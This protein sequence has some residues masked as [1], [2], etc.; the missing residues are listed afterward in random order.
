MKELINILLNVIIGCM[1]ITFI[2]FGC[3]VILIYAVKCF[4]LG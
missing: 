4:L 3:W 1:G 2:G